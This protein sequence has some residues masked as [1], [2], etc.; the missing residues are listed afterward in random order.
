MYD[1]A[2]KAVDHTLCWCGYWS[3]ENI[4]HKCRLFMGGQCNGSRERR[5]SKS[6]Q[7]G[8]S[9]WSHYYLYYF[10]KF[11]CW[12]EVCA[13]V[14][15]LG[16]LDRFIRWHLTHRCSWKW[17][18]SWGLVSS[19]TLWLVTD[20]VRVAGSWLHNERRVWYLGKTYAQY[21]LARTTLISST[22]STCIFREPKIF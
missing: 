2:K 15:Y 9:T 21:L 19:V 8:T 17:S 13:I 7:S 16:R 10:G 11:D 4:N 14:L 20:R 6:N 3:H 18:G 1:G 5:Y 12:C 22:R